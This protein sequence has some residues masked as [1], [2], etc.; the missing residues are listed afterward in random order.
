M[1][2]THTGVLEAREATRTQW[3]Q[4]EGAR[5]RGSATCPDPVPM[6]PVAARK[7]MTAIRA[8]EELLVEETGARSALASSAD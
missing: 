5:S 8:C 1:G 7:E 4:W 6:G 2:S 3:L